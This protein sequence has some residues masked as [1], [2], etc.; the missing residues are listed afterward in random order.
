MRNVVCLTLNFLGCSQ[1][2][3]S[4]SV[5]SSLPKLICM[6]I[7]SLETHAHVVAV[8]ASDEMRCR[9]STSGFRTCVRSLP[10]RLPLFCLLDP[11][12]YKLQ[13]HQNQENHR[14]QLPKSQVIFGVCTSLQASNSMTLRLDDEQMPLR[15]CE[16]LA[17]V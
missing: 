1:L 4:S 16:V 13:Q 3:T 17:S 10:F 2:K 14:H 11:R 6:H 5:V 8:E 15:R 12:I 9:R 7:T